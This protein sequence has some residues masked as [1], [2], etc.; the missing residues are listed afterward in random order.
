MRPIVLL[1]L[2]IH[3][4][5][6]FNNEGLSIKEIITSAPERYQRTVLFMVLHIGLSYC[7][8]LILLAII[9]FSL[10]FSNQS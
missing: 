7:K 2:I 3:Y 8:I 5:V 1:P 6:Q 9:L 4:L 10:V